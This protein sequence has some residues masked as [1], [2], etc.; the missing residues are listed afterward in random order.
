MRLALVVLS[1]LSAISA[2]RNHSEPPVTVN[3]YNPDRFGNNTHPFPA[4]PS[5]WEQFYE[6]LF[7]KSN[8]TRAARSVEENGEEESTESS[9]EE[10]AFTVVYTRRHE[11]GNRPGNH[12]NGHYP[13]G[14]FAN[15]TSPFWERFFEK[16]FGKANNTRAARSVEEGED[17][18]ATK[19]YRREGTNRPRGTG[20]PDGSRGPRGTGRP[21]GSNGPRGT[22][23]PQPTR[24][25]RGTGRPS[26][27]DRPSGIPQT[28]HRPLRTVSAKS[29]RGSTAQ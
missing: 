27:S 23:R 11:G 1:L 26:G 20:R 7:G 13:H 12:S 4:E 5:F 16:Y 2:H 6:R 17:A 19:V 9:E 3:Y 15:S 8:R 25:P 29:P 18:F 22:G 24:G 28:S 10:E 21:H 14:G